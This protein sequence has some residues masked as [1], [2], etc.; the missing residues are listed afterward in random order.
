M[1]IELIG[2]V[3]AFIILFA[4]LMIQMQKWKD[5]DLIYDLTNAVGGLLLIIY[6]V[7]IRS[8]PFIVINL[9]WFV[10]SV[11]DVIGYYKN[12]GKNRVQVGVK[13]IL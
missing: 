12:G 8:Y 11:W 2:I 7:I 5:D 13:K 3:G 9:V 4:F 1:I 6:A 10:V